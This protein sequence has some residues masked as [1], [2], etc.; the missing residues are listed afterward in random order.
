MGFAEFFLDG[1]V[2]SSSFWEWYRGWWNESRKHPESILWIRF[3]DL[4][5]SLPTE[6]A[7]VA[8]F[9]GISITDPEAR[10]VAERCGFS[11]MKQETAQRDKV[12]SAEGKYVKVGHIREGKVGGWRD[13]MRPETVAQ[14][15]HL[16]SALRDECGI[17]L[18]D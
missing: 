9:L 8:S 15:D 14:F 7:R 2:E 18:Y 16:T 13:T 4:K 6:V 11:S 17:D 12:A 3:E 1:R 10:M 5:A